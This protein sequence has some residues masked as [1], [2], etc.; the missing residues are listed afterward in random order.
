MCGGGRCR[1]FWYKLRLRRNLMKIHD[2]RWWLGI[3]QGRRK[4]GAKGAMA[5][6]DFADIEKRTEAEINKTL[7]AVPPT[8]FWTFRHP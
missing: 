6:L 2:M 7:L 5:P 3:R 4:Q 1:F 8:D